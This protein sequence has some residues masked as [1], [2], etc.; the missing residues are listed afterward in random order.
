[1]INKRRSFSELFRAFLQFVCNRSHLFKTPSWNKQLN[2]ASVWLTKGQRSR[3]HQPL[4][5]KQTMTHYYRVQ[6][7]NR[8]LENT[9]FAG[10]K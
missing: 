7:K 10:H 5:L 4:G 6:N 9:R 2:V 1:M 3:L 8:P